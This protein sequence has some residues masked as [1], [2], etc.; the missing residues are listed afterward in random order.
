MKNRLRVRLLTLAPAARP[1]NVERADSVG[2]TE[3]D[4]FLAKISYAGH[5]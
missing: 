3:E 1:E 5:N 4:R 2:L